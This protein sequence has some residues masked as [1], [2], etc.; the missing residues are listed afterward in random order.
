MVFL[1]R[2]CNALKDHFRATPKYFINLRSPSVEA[3]RNQMKK[4]N[5]VMSLVFAL[6]IFFLFLLHKLEAGLTQAKLLKHL[7]ALTGI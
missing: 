3:R 1:T 6:N 5:H 4:H 7:Q 2:T